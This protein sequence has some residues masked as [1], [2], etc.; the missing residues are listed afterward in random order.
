MPD[1]GERILEL[2]ADGGNCYQ[3]A[4]LAREALAERDAEVAALQAENQHFRETMAQS[5]CS[6]LEANQRIAD[7]QREAAAIFTPELE[8]LQAE[9]M[10]L[11]TEVLAWRNADLHCDM[12]GYLAGEYEANE[13]DFTGAALREIVREARDANGQLQAAI[14]GRGEG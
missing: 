14:G 5:C 6:R 8:R 2:M 10:R 13:P 12:L 4:D 7:A 1:I 11:T 9:V 3:V